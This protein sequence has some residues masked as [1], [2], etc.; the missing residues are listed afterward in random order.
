MF[1][2]LNVCVT[3]L[4]RTEAK[5]WKRLQSLRLFVYKVAINR[6][7]TSEKIWKKF[8]IVSGPYFK[9]AKMSLNAKLKRVKESGGSKIKHHASIQAED[10]RKC[11]ESGVFGGNSPLSSVRVNWFNISLFFCRRGQEN[12][13]KIDKKQFC[14]QKGRKS[15]GIC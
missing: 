15:S 7:L 1:Y 9:T 12:Q 2:F 11:Y 14:F 4:S 6:Y 5:R 8:S 10:V 3:V 13:R